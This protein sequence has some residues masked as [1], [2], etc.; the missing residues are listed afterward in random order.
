MLEDV[1]QTEV[2][3]EPLL[4]ALEHAAPYALALDQAGGLIFS[5]AQARE[6]L[7]ADA[8]GEVRQHLQQ[9]LALLG[10]GTRVVRSDQALSTAGSGS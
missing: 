4:E 9:H 7:A 3:A 1:V 6:L 5:N 8:A 2:P 10:A